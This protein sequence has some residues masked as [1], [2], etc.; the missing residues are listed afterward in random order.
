MNSLDFSPVSLEVERR[1]IVFRWPQKGRI[2]GKQEE[3]R[4][5]TVREGEISRRIS[6]LVSVC[7][8]HFRIRALSVKTEK[9][10]QIILRLGK[11]GVSLEQQAH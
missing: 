10:R 9:R 3:I 7:G 2:T 8:P 11:A 6:P 5:R 4:G 1:L